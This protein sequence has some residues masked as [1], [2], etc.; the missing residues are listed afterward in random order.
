MSCAKFHCHYLT[1]MVIVDWWKQKIDLKNI[2]NKEVL[3]PTC[4]SE[5]AV[6]L[7]VCDF[8]WSI[9]YAKSLEC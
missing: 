9:N 5:N 8:L 4:L 6:V 1:R 2:L 7:D 3:S